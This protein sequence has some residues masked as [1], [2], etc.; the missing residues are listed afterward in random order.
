MK[1]DLRKNARTCVVQALY[2]WK[3]SK[4]DFN[5]IK[6]FFIKKNEKK[7]DINYFED[8]FIGIV[9]NKKKI[10]SLIQPYILKNINRIGKIEKSILRMS[11]Y[12]LLKRKDIPYKVV[13]NEAI[14]LSKIF[15]SHNSHKIING[16]LDKAAYKIRL[17]R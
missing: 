1:I 12:E 11:F 6:I 13:I 7:I 15:C 3:I 8:I 16:V 2:A 4:N 5:E 17:Q 9:I 14:E 10:D